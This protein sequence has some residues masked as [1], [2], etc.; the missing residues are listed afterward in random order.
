MDWET[1]LP[2]PC[3]NAA[4]VN[5]CPLKSGGLKAV[6]DLV[7]PLPANVQPIPEVPLK[8]C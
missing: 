5:V 7:N 4:W 6:P 8:S 2:A 3:K 1:E